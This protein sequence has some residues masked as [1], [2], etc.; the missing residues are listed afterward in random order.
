MLCVRSAWGGFVTSNRRRTQTLSR[1]QASL[2]T[3]HPGAWSPR[4]SN[5]HCPHVLIT[6][7]STRLL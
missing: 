4:L 7:H 3:P 6:S 2:L 1:L 5:L